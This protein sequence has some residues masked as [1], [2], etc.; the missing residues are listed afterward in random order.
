[1]V[2]RSV[3]GALLR[4]ESMALETSNGPDLI[5]V[6]QEH[7]GEIYLLV[8]DATSHRGLNGRELA[9]ALAVLLPHTKVFY[10]PGLYR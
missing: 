1:M 3:G 5:E 7:L 8:T 2:H 9:E 10:R 4:C 6:F